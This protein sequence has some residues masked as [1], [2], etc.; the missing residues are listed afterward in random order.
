MDIYLH[1]GT[2]KTGSSYLQSL[3]A[4]NRETLQEKGIWFPHAGKR[5]AELQQGK[6]SAGNAQ[7]L[8]DALEQDNWLGVERLLGAWL[9]ESRSHA[10]E[11]LLLSNELLLLALAKPN[12]LKRLLQIITQAGVQRVYS[13]LIIREP[14]DQALSLYK[15][16]AKFGKAPLLA[17]WPEDHYH[18]GQGLQLFLAA[19][20]S[21]PLQLSVRKYRTHQLERLFFQD[22]LGI[23]GTWLQPKQVVN[24]SLS[25]S[26]LLLIRQL[27][28]HDA[29][30]PRF[31]YERLL[32]L[33]RNQK[34]A[35]PKLTQYYKAILS[36]H[37]SKYKDTWETCNQFLS[38][39]EK[40]DLSFTDVYDTGKEKQVM[41]FSAAQGEAIASF[42]RE[43]STPAFQWKMRYK[44]YRNR[45]GL[46]RNKF[47]SKKR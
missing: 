14:V 9:K 47:L 36:Q 17:D 44:K 32:A 25:L 2:E 35:E 43:A 13:L 6:I 41:T 11:Q 38:K 29:W 12:K 34:A 3:A 4:I 23:K 10:C 19:A 5:E 7:S 31:L 33:P 26:E 46:F 39:D 21:S 20:E 42:M 15:H 30:I 45:L 18:Y 40:L 22:W 27:R 24:P 16:R 28:E 1:I 8:T 37:L